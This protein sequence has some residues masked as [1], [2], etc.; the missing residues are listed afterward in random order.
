VAL[1]LPRADVIAADFSD[2]D[3]GIRDVVVALN[4]AGVETFESCEGGSGHGY[5]DPTVRFYGG[6]SEGMR[7]LAAALAA[8]LP[9]AELRRVWIVLDDE[10][11]GPWWELTFSPTM[12]Q[13]GRPVR[14]T[15]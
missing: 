11:S 12:L 7:A 10:P 1:P 13:P 15:D 5:P 8:N 4:R 6:R 2:V 3:D 14:V 9:V